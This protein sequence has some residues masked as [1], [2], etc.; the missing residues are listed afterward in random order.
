MKAVIYARYSS[1]KQTEQSI[2]GQLR[3]CY[4]FAERNGYSIIHEYIDRAVTGKFDNR[5]QFQKM[6]EDSKKQNFEAILVYKFDRFARNR[7][8]SAVYKRTLRSRGIKVVSAMEFISDGPEGILL[9][10][11]LEGWAEYFSADLAQKVKRGMRESV[12]KGHFIGGRIPYGFNIVNKRYEINETEAEVVRRTYEMFLSGKT[13]KEISTRFNSEHLTNKKRQ[14]FTHHQIYDLLTRPIYIGKLVACGIEVEN[15]VTPIISKE[16]YMRAQELLDLNPKIKSRGDFLLNGKIFCGKCGKAMTG[17]SGTGRSK[18][19]YYYEC[20]SEKITVKKE[21]IEDL[22]YDTIK[23]FLNNTE[24]SSTL[25]VN[26]DKYIN[27]AKEADDSDVIKARLKF[28]DKEITNITNAILRGIINDEIKRKNEELTVEKAQLEYELAQ[29]E[30]DPFN[31]LTGQNVVAMLKELAQSQE[32]MDKALL[33]RSVLHKVIINE[34]KAIII[35]NATR[36]NPSKKETN[37]REILEIALSDDM[38]RNNSLRCTKK[39]H[40]LGVFLF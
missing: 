31:K 35:L 17:T 30:R 8:D 27:E 38:V 18:I 36:N 7:Y 14:P 26:I 20:K 19:Y 29:I 21:L 39:K 1:D 13:I 23:N 25:A 40:L 22:V 4:D 6:L 9:E 28:V 33:I 11:M 32:S 24:R 3:V 15:V 2:E 16:K 37:T 10:S 5:A 12:Y 34:G